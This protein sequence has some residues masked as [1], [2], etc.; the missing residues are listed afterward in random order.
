MH[1][2]LSTLAIVFA[3]V[4][5]AVHGAP[6]PKGHVARKEGAFWQSGLHQVIS[7]SVPASANAPSATLSLA[8]RKEGEF[9]QSGVHQVISGTSTVNEPRQ[10][11]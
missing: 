11:R 8:A 7:D 6:A 9:W 5:S 4:V 10:S 2:A 3:A 1:F